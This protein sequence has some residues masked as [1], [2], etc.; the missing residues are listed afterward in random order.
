[1]RFVKVNSKPAVGD[2][3]TAIY[4]VNQATS[5]SKDE[6]TLLRN[7][8]NND[9]NYFTLTK[10]NNVL[11]RTQ[12]FEDHHLLQ[13]AYV[14]QF[15]KDNERSLRDLG[16]DF[17]NESSD[18]VENNQHNKVNY[19]KLLNLD[20]ITMKRSPTLSKEI[21]NKRYIDDELDE[22]TILRF[23]PTLESCIKVSVGNDAYNLA[24][25]DK[26]QIPDTTI[27]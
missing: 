2:N 16:I 22:N 10:I 7:N 27:I 4:Y 18:L 24:K 13:K 3:L 6:T 5:N 11:L 20:S 8:Q 12:A 21:S 23:I 1:M 26:I 15:Q 14:D 25:D 9:F 19:T 17:Y